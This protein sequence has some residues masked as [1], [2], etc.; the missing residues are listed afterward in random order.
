MPALAA[1]LPFARDDGLG[2]SAG[3]P[4]SASVIIAVGIAI[5]VA[6]LCLPVK[7]AVLAVLMTAA[8]ATLMGLLA[9]QQIGGVTGDVFGAVEQAA[10][11]AVLLTLAAQFS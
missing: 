10:E 2:K 11:T 1:N 5:V 3:R 8:S 6:L 7:A 4:D 9:W